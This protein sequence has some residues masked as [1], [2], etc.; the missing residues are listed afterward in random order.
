VRFSGSLI[1]SLLVS[2]TLENAGK[3]CTGTCGE[4]SCTGET[5]GGEVC[6]VCAGAFGGVACGG[7][8][9]EAASAWDVRDR[10]ACA[11]EACVGG[12]SGS[13]AGVTDCAV[14][15]CGGTTRTASC[16]SGFS[17]LLASTRAVTGSARC[18]AATNACA[19]CCVRKAGAQGPVCGHDNNATASSPSNSARI[20]TYSSLAVCITLLRTA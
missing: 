16:S 6:R 2:E 7:V 18:I 5:C 3:I 1:A 8:G 14:E 19:S 15:D 20:F 10:G 12:T 9:V 17:C 11:R 13:C 4:E